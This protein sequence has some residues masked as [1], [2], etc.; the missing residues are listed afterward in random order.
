MGMGTLTLKRGQEGVPFIPTTISKLD[1]CLVGGHSP[2]TLSQADRVPASTDLVGP[3]K[4]S[5]W[6]PYFSFYLSLINCP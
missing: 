4:I 6:K 1:I 2:K 5:L 3:S